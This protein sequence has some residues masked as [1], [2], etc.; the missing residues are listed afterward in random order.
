MKDAELLFIE[1]FFK[2]IMEINKESKKLSQD[3]PIE[4]GKQLAY[5]DV[6]SI[7]HQQVIAFGI[8]PVDVGMEGFD[9]DRDA[10]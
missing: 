5:Y 2:I 1:D 6:L 4:M 9:P 3:D 7:L 10:L 8:D